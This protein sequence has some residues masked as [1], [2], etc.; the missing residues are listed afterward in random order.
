MQLFKYF[1]NTHTIYTLGKRAEK[2]T[3]GKLGTSLEFDQNK[4]TTVINEHKQNV[5]VTAFRKQTASYGIKGT[6][7][8]LLE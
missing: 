8:W 4:N 5:N 1:A 2:G 6:L 7:I 3:C